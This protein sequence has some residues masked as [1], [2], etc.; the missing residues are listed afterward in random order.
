M[1]RSSPHIIRLFLTYASGTLLF[2]SGLCADFS[3]DWAKMKRIQPKG[4]V[5]YRAAEPI[6]VDGK[7]DELSWQK[8]PWSE[9]FVDI[10]GDAKPLPP[11]RTRVKMLWDDL[12]FYF[13]AELEEPNLRGTLTNRD[14][15]IFHDND[16]EI[17]I[18]PNG[19]SHEYYEFE[20]NALNTVWD[21]LLKKPY[22]DGGPA[23]NEWDIAGLKTA[24][25]VRGTLNDPSDKDQGWTLEVAFPWKALAEYAQR[26]TPPRDGEQWRVDFSRVEWRLEIE[27]GKY[28]RTEGVKEN[29]WVW[30]PTGI[31]DMHRPEKWGYVQFSTGPVTKVKYKPDPAAPARDLL[32]EIYYAE[33]DYHEKHGRFGASLSELGLAHVRWSRLAD[34]PKIQITVDGFWASAEIKLREKQTQRWHIRQDAKV[35]TE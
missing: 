29:N 16:F 14:S 18:D 27:E 15:V 33:R 26:P 13:A 5:C 21:L 17:F 1:V 24:V 34:T 30:S 8:V 4:Y 31:I 11:L 32:Q 20:M 2:G 6:R 25:Q 28:K 3:A 23:I 7:L 9:P 22:K 10:E 35:W 19:D 12:Y